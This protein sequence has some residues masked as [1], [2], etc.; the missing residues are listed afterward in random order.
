MQHLLRH[1]PTAIKSNLLIVLTIKFLYC[2]LFI[3]RYEKRAFYR[4]ESFGLAVSRYMYEMFIYF[5]LMRRLQKLNAPKL[6]LTPSARES[7]STPAHAMP[8]LAAHTQTHTRISQLGDAA[9]SVYASVINFPATR[10]MRNEG[11]L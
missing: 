2:A 11:K 3:W 6:A 1:E 10:R 8:R 9:V 5:D 7:S 4:L